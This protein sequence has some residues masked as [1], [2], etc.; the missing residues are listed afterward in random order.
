ML[1]LSNQFVIQTFLTINLLYPGIS[2]SGLVSNEIGTSVKCSTCEVSFERQHE[3][4][5]ARSP[6]LPC[7]WT[8]LLKRDRLWYFVLWQIEHRNWSNKI[9]CSALEAS[10]L[11]TLWHLTFLGLG[12]CFITKVPSNSRNLC[13]CNPSNTSNSLRL[14]FFPPLIW[15]LR[16]RIRIP[17][18]S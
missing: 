11:L 10:L 5:L 4:F 12:F 16:D 13:F 8:V 14:A 18:F 3:M 6:P 15:T 17:T 1:V 7:F 2:K 9:L